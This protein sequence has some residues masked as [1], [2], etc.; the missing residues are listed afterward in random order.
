MK[1]DDPQQAS[2]AA[3]ESRSVGTRLGRHVDLVRKIGDTI[4]GIVRLGRRHR[5][6]FLKGAVASIGIV[7]VRLALPW[8]F[9]S[10]AALI[11]GTDS[12]TGITQNVSVQILQLSL[13]FLVCVTILGLLD[14][15]ARL[16]FSRFSIATT[17]D[18]RQKVFSS[19]LG[20]SPESRKVA[21]GDLV[22]RLIGDAARVKAGMQGFLLHVAT[23]G[24]LFIGVAVVLWSVDPRM[25]Q[26]FAVAALLI[27]LL[28]AWGALHVFEISL[29]HRYKE[30]K[31]ANKIYS[32]LKKPDSRSKLKRINK[33]S[34]R[35][36]ATL[37]RLQ[38][39]VTWAA[40]VVFGLAVV[41]SIW[42]GMQAVGEGTVS[43][44][45]LVLFMFYALMM[46][47][48]ITRLARQGTRTGKILG[49]AH[50][51]IQMLQPREEAVET[52]SVLRLR[53]LKKSLDLKGI[54]SKLPADANGGNGPRDGLDLTIRRGERVAIVDRSGTASALLIEAIAG[55]GDVGD[56]SVTWDSA[57]LSGINRSALRNQVA[58]FR[59]NPLEEGAATPLEQRFRQIAVAARQRASVQCFLDP[60]E[61]LSPRDVEL[62]MSTLSSREIAGVP[63]TIVSTRQQHGLDGF[64]RIVHLEDGC[65]VFDGSC[66][67]W[68]GMSS[69]SESAT[70]PAQQRAAKQASGMRILFS[71]YAPVHFRCFQPLYEQLRN[72]PGVDVFVS[73]GLRTKIDDGYEYDEAAMYSGFGLPSESI[74]SVDEIRELDFDVQFSSHTKLILPRRVERRIQIFHGVSF[75]NK[76]VRPE[77]MGC[78]HYFVIGPYMLN[79][80]VQTGLLRKNDPRVAKIGFMKTDPLVDG[81]LDKAEILRS[82]GFDGTR[83]IIL[84]APTGA[85][86]NSLETMGEDVIRRLMN[87]DEYDLL[88]KP[89]DHPKN[90]DVDWATYLR[91]YE[92]AHCRIVQPCD[93]VIP[94]LHAA[95]LLISD[96]S[97]VANEFTLLDRPIVY[98]DTPE[99]LAQAGDACRSMLD[100][101]TWGRGGGLIARDASDVPALVAESLAD[102]M[103]LSLVRRRI[104]ENLFFNHG[105]ATRAAMNW[106]QA[107]IL[108]AR[109]TTEESS[110][111]LTAS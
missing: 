57:I 54:G 63:T 10:V 109:T 61:G 75:R 60:G 81:S 40:H 66:E 78:D 104:A 47:G 16:F 55:E 111:E 23:N 24:L 14:Y 25:G 107:N 64:D 94:M 84:Y 67:D 83:P 29:Q 99:L 65:V 97:S 76:A 58:L 27:S 62:V 26:L 48:P 20:I 50:R 92:G 96:A 80:F 70:F 51:L 15:L 88:I 41:G 43:T 42:S 17:R 45:G 46:R 56:G 21:S 35:Y 13:L 108:P 90:K 8:P 77:N 5:A 110:H 37:T 4:R 87:I 71:G 36:E 100:L 22:S 34:G 98:L 82:M 68:R 105:Q 95:D 91:R 52:E 28:T 38:G 59:P 72:W 93:D 79:R 85:K 33:S 19:T 32:S 3:P 7:A 73:G 89:H 103:R 53:S 74:L 12:T 101:D 18:L 2:T 102:P 106:L 86:C 49:P 31:L 44:G 39:R 9:H 6:L 69:S 11:T 1:I 30:G